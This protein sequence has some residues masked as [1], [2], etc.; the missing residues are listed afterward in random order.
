M[1]TPSPALLAAL[2]ITVM[3]CGSGSGK[4]TK[5]AT[6][7]LAEAPV[8][9]S[10][11][12]APVAA[13]GDDV[14]DAE[15]T[16]ATERE[17][18]IVQMVADSTEY[19]EQAMLLHL[20]YKGDCAAFAEKMLALEPLAQSIRG[21]FVELVSGG[22]DGKA[23]AGEV[24]RR[25]KARAK[26]AIAR[27]EATLGKHGKTMADFDKTEAAFKAKCSKHPRVVEVMD[28]VGVFKRKTPLAEGPAASP[29]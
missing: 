15:A 13:P 22:A 23:L 29:Q 26:E 10:S 21:R 18:Y 5:S 8:R 14:H 3:A 2:S 11:R 6:E 17:A 16:E 28:R 25:L 24:D 20:E 19:T 1:K 7:K 4:S 27:I 9:A 12:E